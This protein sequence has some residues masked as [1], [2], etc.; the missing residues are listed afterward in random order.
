M[1]EISP[2]S[3]EHSGVIVLA[4]NVQGVLE[5]FKEGLLLDLP[6]CIEQGRLSERDRFGCREVGKCG[7]R[8]VVLAADKFVKISPESYFR[9]R[10]G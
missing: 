6:Q 9:F 4:Q 1:R 3:L 8:F 5:P 10:V 7:E 2:Y